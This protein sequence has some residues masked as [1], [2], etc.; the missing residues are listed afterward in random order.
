MIYL[1]DYD[2][3][4][5]TDIVMDTAGTGYELTDTITYY[6]DLPVGTS[7]IEITTPQKDNLLLAVKDNEEIVDIKVE[8][9]GEDIVAVEI[10][11]LQNTQIALSLGREE[12]ILT[13]LYKIEI[14][15][16]ADGNTTE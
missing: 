5:N 1:Y 2:I 15:R 9:K 11:C 13:E 4:F 8:N 14:K 6:L 12:D 7:R 16:T 3:R 10:T